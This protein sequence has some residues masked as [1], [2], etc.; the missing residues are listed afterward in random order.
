MLRVK[1]VILYIHNKTYILHYR[2]RNRLLHTRYKETRLIL[3]YTRYQRVLSANP[4]LIR[5]YVIL[6]ERERE[7]RR[8]YIC[9]DKPQPKRKIGRV[10]SQAYDLQ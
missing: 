3:V 8:K 10:N 2:I 9:I 4:Y 7:T 6:R 5:P 1:Y